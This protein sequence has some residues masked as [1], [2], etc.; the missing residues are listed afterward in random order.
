MKVVNDTPTYI[1]QYFDVTDLPETVWDEKPNTC[2]VSCVG[3]I[4]FL[5]PDIVLHDM[6]RKYRYNTQFQNTQFQWEEHLI[7]YLQECGHICEPVTK[8]AWPNARFIKNSELKKM[9]KEIDKGKVIFYHKHGHYQ[10]MVGYIKHNNGRYTYIFNDPAGD[11]RVQYN[12]RSRES[13]HLVGY[14]SYMVKNEPIYCR[15]WSVTL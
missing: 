9:R 15:C 4:C 12:Y 2:N 8:S 7:S 13:G 1:N 3:M 5:S 14:D 10:L 6:Y 11:R